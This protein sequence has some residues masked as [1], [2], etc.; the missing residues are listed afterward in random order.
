MG[1]MG[2]NMCYCST[3]PPPTSGQH[4]S[5]LQFLLLS[6]WK[7]LHPSLLAGIN[8][9]YL[10]LI[11]ISVFIF[12][13]SLIFLFFR[14]N[15]H[16]AWWTTMAFSYFCPREGQNGF[17]S[18]MPL[19]V[20]IAVS[21]GL[22]FPLGCLS[23]APLLLLESVAFALLKPIRGSSSI[24]ICLSH[25]L[26]QHKIIF[27]LIAFCPFCPKFQSVSVKTQPATDLVRA[28]ECQDRDHPPGN[29]GHC[30]VVCVVP[31]CFYNDYQE[32]E[33]YHESKSRCSF[34]QL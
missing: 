21:P 13:S 28:S 20:G 5:Q 10:L 25:E 6:L 9:R 11:T 22:L 29:L 19:H 7:E 15:P 12:Y 1:C 2:A 34:L 14:Y 24:Q 4:S 3:L 26:H 30:C 33:T 27:P 8:C 18:L 31:Y 32:V 17:V 23:M 16:T